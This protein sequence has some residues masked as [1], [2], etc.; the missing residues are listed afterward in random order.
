METLLPRV[1]S[2]KL[3]IWDLDE[4]FW[5][6]TLSEEGVIPIPEN[7]ELVKQLSERG[8]INSIVSKN[9]FETAKEKLQEL[10][11]WDYFVFPAIDWSP[12]GIL[13]RN[14]I[15]NCQLRSPNVLFLDDNHSNLEEARFYNPKIKAHFPDF[16]PQM[17]AN[18][19]L[20]GK[21]D[22]NLSRLKQYKI[23]EK[24]HDAKKS[25]NDNLDFL[26]SSGIE[27]ELIHKLESHKDR[28]HELLQ[29]TNQLNFTKIRL[30]LD[31][32]QALI[33]SPMHKSALVKVKDNFGDYGIIGFYSL[34]SIKNSLDHFVFSCRILNLGIP[35]FIY[36]KLGFPDLK[37]VPDVAEELDR[38]T[39]DW[40][41]E[42]NVSDPS[43]PSAAQTP[44]KKEL[45][46]LFRGPCDY[47]QTLFYLQNSGFDIMQETNYVTE[48]IP[49]YP[50]HTNTLI[51]AIRL[52]TAQKKRILAVKDIPFFDKHYYD[53]SAL[54][55][56][57]EYIV[58]ALETDYHQHLYRHKDSDIKL[59]LGKREGVLT[60]AANHPS[61]V[62]YFKERGAAHLGTKALVNFSINFT[63]IGLISPEEF[64]QN[65]CTIRTLIPAYKKLI[66]INAPTPPPGHEQRYEIMNQ[67]VDDFIENN[68]N[69]QLVDLRK[70]TNTTIFSD[71]GSK[72]F[73][74]KT[75]LEIASLLLEQLPDASNESVSKNISP[76]LVFKNEIRMRYLVTKSF[77]RKNVWM[78]IKRFNLLLALELYLEDGLAEI[79][80]SCKFI[81]F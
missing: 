45:P 81:I 75:Y 64:Y 33:N 13:I 38:S 53:T 41:D 5:H 70:L 47:K 39:P 51:D 44:A 8:I 58:M 2:I 35:Q 3:V 55:T 63:H 10:G 74:R 34:D 78:K 73:N 26:K 15:E 37:V 67:M 59:A 16:I 57:A 20:A 29:R 62:H 50:T 21:V 68:E 76:F 6:G 9:N 31:E 77:L 48:N 52:T 12:K 56:N 17:L 28:I 18:E 46:L 7:I 79:I 43:M 80:L 1:E 11:I 4:T 36:A 24:K 66:L 42:R 71:N 61:L 32:V 25:F 49:S 40:I 65:L 22:S 54:E 69:T 72:N 60:E 14:I 27:I 30:D 19:A 23:L